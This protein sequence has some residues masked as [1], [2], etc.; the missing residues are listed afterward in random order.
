MSTRLD[1]R[2][3]QSYNSIDICIWGDF[4]KDE[5]M[6][7]EWAKELQFISQCALAYCK[8]VYDIERFERIRE[9]SAEMV[10]RIADLP[11]GTV[12]DLFCDE[13]GYQTPKMDCRAAIVEDGKIL[14]VQESSGLWAL[15]GGWVDVG[16]SVR[17]NTIKEVREE[18][19]LEVRPTRVIAL[20]DRKKHLKPDYIH[21]ICTVYVLC[22][23]LSGCF[24]PNVETI[25]SGFFDVDHLPPIATGKCNEEQIRM[26][27][28]AANDDNWR[29][30]F[31]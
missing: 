20:Y 11:V 19:G 4:M 10:S 9:I 14:L 30:E 12:R 24:K 25:A 2:F 15:P 17:E 23:R 16:L 27:L 29:V 5:N 1:T 6:W 31:D 26:C 8:D 21:G 3:A 13:S 7:L 28:H 22:E 18:A